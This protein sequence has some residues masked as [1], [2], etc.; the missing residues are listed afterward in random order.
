[1]SK[2]CY[3]C[4][5]ECYRGCPFYAIMRKLRSSHNF[6]PGMSRAKRALKAPS[7]S[8]TMVQ[9]LDLEEKE[10]GDDPS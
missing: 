8:G 6:L 3:T 9:F 7:L 10:E 5:R 4:S 2:P 1:M